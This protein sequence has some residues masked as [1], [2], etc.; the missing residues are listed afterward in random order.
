MSTT[1]PAATFTAPVPVSARRVPRSVVISTWAVPVMV[2]GQFALLAVVPVVLVVR[3]V[4]RN[5][6]LRHL[7]LPA[8]LLAASWTTPLAVWILRPDRAE[9]LSK[10]ISP[11]FV[12]L[13]LAAS[14]GMLLSLR[15][16]R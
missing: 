5:A 1:A 12:A 16:P 4:L 9:S 14:T 6:R 10:D 11:A 2:L 7:R 8:L 3:G 15:R 13:I